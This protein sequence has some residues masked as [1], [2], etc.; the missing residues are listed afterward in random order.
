MSTTLDA[1]LTR[2]ARERM[3]QRGIP[4]AA[5]EQV[6]RYGCERHDGHG[7]IIHFVDREGRRRIART[8][9]V[10]RADVDRLSGVYVVVTGGIVVTVG[11][12]TRRV[13]HS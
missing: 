4:P 7:G 13:R 12:R 3:Q 2:H 11:H 6:L 8:G 1:I 5:V 9:A 10:R